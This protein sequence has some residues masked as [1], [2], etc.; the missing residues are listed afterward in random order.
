M[1]ADTAKGAFAVTH[2]E[3][4][5]YLVKYLLAEDRRYKNISIPENEKARFDLFRS[6]VN[7]RPPKPAEKFFFAGAGRISP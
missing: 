7:V 2:S 5:L 4:L 1:I 3:K 6:L